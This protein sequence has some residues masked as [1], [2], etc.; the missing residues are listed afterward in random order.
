MTSLNRTLASA[1]IGA[2]ILALSALS[3]SAWIACS[4]NVCWH[5]Q[6]I[7]SYPSSAGIIVHQDNWNGGPGVTYR[8][9]TGRGYWKGDTWTDF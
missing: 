7:Y 6:E 4:G 3:A 5:T 9:H 2:G 1:L 8:E